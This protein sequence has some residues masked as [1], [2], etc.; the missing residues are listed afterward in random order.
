MATAVGTHT[1]D[2]TS[3][4]ESACNTMKSFVSEYIGGQPR[5]PS[6]AIQYMTGLDESPDHRKDS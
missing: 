2:R 5:L 1:Q 4:Q 3:L 6:G